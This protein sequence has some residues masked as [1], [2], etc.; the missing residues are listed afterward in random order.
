MCPPPALILLIVRFFFLMIRRPPRSTLFPYTTLFRS[1]RRWRGT[2]YFT[3]DGTDRLAVIQGGTMRTLHAATLIIA[4]LA[5][6]RPLAAQH[7]QKKELTA[8]EIEKG[9]QITTAYD[10]VSRLRPMWLNP[11]D[12]TFQSAGAGQSVQVAQVRVYVNDFNVGDVEYLKSVSAES[13]Q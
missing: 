9:A 10:A 13:V 6:G 2:P 1:P 3:G 12:V 11:Q 5:V 4:A 7:Y 8:E